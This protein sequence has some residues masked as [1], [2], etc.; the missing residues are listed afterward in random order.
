MG[1]KLDFNECLKDS[2]LFRRNLSFA[3]NDLETYENTYKKIYENSLAF[4]ADGLRYL[5]SYRRMI[6]SIQ[7]LGSLLSEKD[8]GFTRRK[9]DNFCS[10]LKD[11][12]HCEENFLSESFKSIS[13]KANKFLE[14]DIK[15]LKEQRKQ[16]E[17]ISQ[18]LDTAYNKNAEAL[19]NKPQICEEMEKNLNGVKKIYGQNGLEYI[20]QI[21]RFYLVR[22]HSILNIIQLYSQSLK[23]FYQYGNV[24]VYEHDSELAEIS[25]NLSL[26]NENEQKCMELMEQQHGILRSNDYH[27]SSDVSGSSSSSSASSLAKRQHNLIMSGYLYKRSHHNTFKKWNRRWFTLFNSKLFYQ[28]RSDFNSEVNEM[29][30]DLR[31][32]KVREVNDGERRFTFEIVSPKCRHILQADS[33]KDCNHWVKSIDKAINDA[34]N[35]LVSSQFGSNDYQSDENSASQNEFMESMDILNSFNETNNSDHLTVPGNKSHSSRNLLETGKSF[36]STSLKKR[37]EIFDNKNSLLM[38]LKGNQA[39][40]DCGAPNPSWISINIGA[41][42]CIEC[43]G[44]HRGLGVH[45]SKVRSLNLDELAHE[46][47]SLQ[48]SLGNDLVNSIYEKMF[49]K[50]VELNDNLKIQRATPKCDNN[51][52]ES[53]IR[54]KYGSKIF[55]RP[56]KNVTVKI[57]KSFDNEKSILNIVDCTENVESTEQ[58]DVMYVKIQNKDELLHLASAHGD[59]KLMS[60]AIA[61]DADRNSII[62]RQNLYIDNYLDTSYNPNETLNGYSPLIKAVLSRCIPAVELLLLNGAKVNICDFDGKTA[63]HHATILNDLKLVCLLLKRGADPLALD[64]NNTDPI[65]I[66]TDNCQPNIVTILRVAKMNNDLKE[67]DLTYSGDPMF[68]EI[69]KDLLALNIPNEDQVSTDYQ[70]DQSGSSD[71]HT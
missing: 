62:D 23:S 27:S 36:S 4:H 69:L 20:C 25:T 29:E 19:K 32:C 40:C 10:L 30:P 37:S 5:D 66:A 42:L 59:I 17:K 48:M 24:L 65:M 52:R 71:Q 11:S 7:D 41:V 57:Q 15:Q 22:S 38:T 26:M 21:N 18:E 1:V 47:L 39:C 6:D 2:P 34:I 3:E 8:E 64:K 68:D 50:E 51:V 55:V 12:R 14:N 61:L 35:N 28:K 45:I 60:Y 13:E 31:V 56:L 58:P 16:F 53:W 44:K 9:I 49:T 54:A 33:Q 63:L 46:T 67:Q 43:S 70:S